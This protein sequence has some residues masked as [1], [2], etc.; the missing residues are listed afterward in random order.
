MRRDETF[1]F[2]MCEEERRILAALARRLERSQSDTVRF[3]I[4]REAERIIE[5]PVAVVS[6]GGDTATGAS[7][8]DSSF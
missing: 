7:A 3:L 6:L 1:K 8:P 4:H 2:R 5:T